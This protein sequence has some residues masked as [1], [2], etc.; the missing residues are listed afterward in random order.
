M[1]IQKEEI[2]RDIDELLNLACQVDA[3]TAAQRGTLVFAGTMSLFCSLYGEKSEQVALLKDMRERAAELLP[4]VVSNTM[5][6]VMPGIAGLLENLKREVQHGLLGS[7]KNRF[8]GEILS[9]F[10][11]LAREAA[12]ENAEGA[13]NVA[14]VLAAAAFEDTIRRMGLEFAGITDR[15]NLSEVI[16]KLKEKGILKGS[17][18]GIAQSFLNFR[19]NALHADWN[20]IEKAS[21]ESVLGF[22]Q[23]LLSKHFG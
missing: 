20:K 21:I 5:L 10:I 6:Q 9:D 11:V 1:D 23:E 3:K 8:A 12:G 13:K 2:I 7:L 19:N 22:V 15:P 17:Q 4:R 16:I 14:A 18:V